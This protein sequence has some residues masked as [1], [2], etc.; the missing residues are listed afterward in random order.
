MQF[1]KEINASKDISTIFK[2]SLYIKIIESLARNFNIDD[3]K[4]YSYKKINKLFK[5]ELK[6]RLRLKTREKDPIISMYKKINK[7]NFSLVRPEAFINPLEFLES[8]YLY[9]ITHK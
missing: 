7:R 5:K 3:T 6:R 4:I 2:K 9:T 8:I 1:R